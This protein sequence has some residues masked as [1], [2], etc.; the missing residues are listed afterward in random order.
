MEHCYIPY[1]GL[2]QKIYVQSSNSTPTDF[3]FLIFVTK[4]I[5]SKSFLL[6]ECCLYMLQQRC[7]NL[8]PFVICC[9]GV[10]SDGNAFSFA[11]N[12]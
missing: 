1:Q 12:I 2:L 3:R 5:A 11:S 9:V 10:K 8:K 4:S 7:L 6:K